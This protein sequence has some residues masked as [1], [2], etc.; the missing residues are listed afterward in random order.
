MNLNIRE[1]SPNLVMFVGTTPNIGTTAAAFAAARALAAGVGAER[2]IAYVCLNLKSSKIARYMGLRPF[3]YGLGEIR[4]ELKAQ[5]LSPERLEKVCLRLKQAPNLYVLHGNAQREQ[6][7]LY[8][9][10]DIEQLLTTAAE[11]FD[12]CIVDCSAYW[13]NAATVVAGMRCGSKMLV[14]VPRSDSFRDD[15]EAWIVHTASIF[16]VAPE[17]FALIVVQAGYHPD[18]YRTSEIQQSVGLTLA[19]VMPY[20]RRLPLEMQRGRLDDALRNCRLFDRTAQDIARM[21]AAQTGIEWMLRAEASMSVR[22]RW[23]ISKQTAE[24]KLGR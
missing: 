23:R 24:V 9:A 8:T 22:R 12:V 19:G 5:H 15:Y 20:E 17:E 16:G 14:T 13:D 1:T 4:G 21:I 18:E 6:A 10:A 2:K 11:A 3:G 7:E